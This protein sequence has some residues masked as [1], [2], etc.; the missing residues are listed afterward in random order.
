MFWKTSQR[1]NKGIDRNEPTNN[2][3]RNCDENK[4][5]DFDYSWSR[6]TIWCFIVRKKRKKKLLS[7]QPI[8]HGREKSEA[9]EQL[10]LFYPRKDGSGVGKKMVGRG[11]GA[12]I[13]NR[14]RKIYRA[15]GV[16]GVKLCAATRDCATDG[17]RFMK[18]MISGQRFPGGAVHHNSLLIQIDRH[19]AKN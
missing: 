2:N 17:H 19:F 14:Q 4:F 5:V 12:R 6:E 10:R 13:R 9:R 1:Q 8:F 3:S 16:T 7:K 18:T 11:S 15:L